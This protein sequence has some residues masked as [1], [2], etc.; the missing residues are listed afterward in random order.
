M[1][2]SIYGIF[3][4]PVQL[5]V[6][7]DFIRQAWRF[8][9]H[10]FIFLRPSTPG[11]IR[12]S[13]LKIGYLAFWLAV[14]AVAILLT[15]VSGI[16]Y[17]FYTSIILPGSHNY[18]IFEGSLCALL[19]VLGRIGTSCAQVM[20]V[21]TPRN[22]S[23]SA[24]HAL[25]LQGSASIMGIIPGS[26]GHQMPAISEDP[27]PEP[28]KQSAFFRCFF[29]TQEDG[30]MKMRTSFNIFG[31]FVSAI[32]SLGSRLHS[33]GGVRV[34]HHQSDQPATSNESSQFSFSFTSFIS[35]MTSP[36]FQNSH[37]STSPDRSTSG[38]GDE[39]K[40]AVATAFGVE[41]TL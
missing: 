36:S 32:E 35:S 37:R 28:P 7:L 22:S 29:V 11:P 31:A 25:E 18:D 15:I 3:I 33:R 19:M 5:F 6:S 38:N 24:R 40:P 23:S 1:V 8:R 17:A 13:H 9:E 34:G 41:C 26:S 2:T 21:I 16:V 20:A 10:L 39:E 14:S 12:K 27:V 30:G 4:V